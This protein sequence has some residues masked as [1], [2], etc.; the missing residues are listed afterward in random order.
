[1][2]TSSKTR[3]NA[4][5]PRLHTGTPIHTGAQLVCAPSAGTLDAGGERSVPRFDSTSV[6]ARNYKNTRAPSHRR[7][8]RHQQGL[9]PEA[10]A[11]CVSAC[12]VTWARHCVGAVFHPNRLELASAVR[13]RPASGRP[14][15]PS[16]QCPH[17][18]GAPRPA[19]LAASNPSTVTRILCS[20]S[21]HPS[22]SP[23]Q[24]SPTADFGRSGS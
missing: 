5:F 15:S 6:S 23:P 7:A 8:H 24:S 3:C 4:R 11:A 21:P 17:R 22:P 1:M 13:P 9:T 10:H 12:P 20:L 16:P 14:P 19:P 2:R 18:W